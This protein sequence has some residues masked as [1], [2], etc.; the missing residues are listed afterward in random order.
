MINIVLP[1]FNEED[2]IRTLLEN[3]DMTLK[4]Y[5][6]DYHIIMVDDGSTDGTVKIVEAFKGIV[7]L[8]ILT[9]A[10]NRGLGES[11]RTGLIRAVETS[12]DNDVI[13]TM[14][15]DN[16]HIPG[17]IM[18]LNR[19]IWEG[20]DVAIAS[21]YVKNARVIG[22]P[23]RRRL[24]GC[25]ASL[26]F[27]IFFPIAGVR[28]YTCGYRAYRASLLKKAFAVYGRE[29]VSEPGF[30]CQ[31]DILLKLRSICPIISEAPILLRYDNRRDASKM[32]VKKT[33]SDTLGLFV[34]SL[35]KRWVS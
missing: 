30:A 18:R 29:F 12:S 14:D 7:S 2:S 26:L 23:W 4:E 6:H 9:H 8:E 21:R 5:R 32:N 20:C 1:V 35:R 10:T 3:I 34:K 11:I 16:T 33:V 13:I 19:N 24:L 15:A 25:G 22:V 31:V 17:L 28:D 27:R